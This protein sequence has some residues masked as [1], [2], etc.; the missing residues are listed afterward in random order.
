M[1]LVTQETEKTSATF[2]SERK[3]FVKLVF[4]CWSKCM[5]KKKKKK[6]KKKDNDEVEIVPGVSI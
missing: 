1:P 5:R 6:K 2:S 3:A 4:K